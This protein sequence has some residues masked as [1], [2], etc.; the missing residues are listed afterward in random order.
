M[1]L[2]PIAPRHVKAKTINP[3]TVVMIRNLFDQLDQVVDEAQAEYKVG[4][5]NPDTLKRH[6][7][8]TERLIQTVRGL[9]S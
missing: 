3:G 4:P 7:R 9:V 5:V 8:V 6:A 2:T 1:P